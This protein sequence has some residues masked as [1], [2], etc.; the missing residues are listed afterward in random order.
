MADSGSLH[1]IGIDWFSN[2]TVGASLGGLYYAVY[3]DPEEYN[4]D[5]VADILRADAEPPEAQF[6][7]V[8][9]ML[10]WLNRD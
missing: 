2:A 4:P 9:D 3:A 10:N 6:N 8:V 1:V 5:L 7:N